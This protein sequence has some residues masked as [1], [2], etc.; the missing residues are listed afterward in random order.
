MY[1]CLLTYIVV[2][3]GQVFV[4]ALCFCNIL[5]ICQAEGGKFIIC[6]YSRPPKS[7]AKKIMSRICVRK[8]DVQVA[9][10][11]KFVE[12]LK[13]HSWM[14]SFYVCDCVLQTIEYDTY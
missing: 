6:L 13:A 4:I 8:F 5:E 2:N 7:Y 9:V 1:G 10:I 3:A 14:V 11:C 12:F